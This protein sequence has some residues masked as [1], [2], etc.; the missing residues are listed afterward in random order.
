MTGSPRTLRLLSPKRRRIVLIDR[1][2]PS[3]A[4]TLAQLARLGW[5]VYTGPAQTDARGWVIPGSDPAF[6]PEPI[7]T[8]KVRR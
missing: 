1:L 8:R 4:T 3:H 2:N 7:E 6:E 5:H